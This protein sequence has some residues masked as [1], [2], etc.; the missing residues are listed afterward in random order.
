M[1]SEESA[2]VGFRKDS[3]K[4]PGRLGK[5]TD[6]E[7]VDNEQVSRFGSFHTDWAAQI[8]YFGQVNVPYIVRNVI[9]GDLPA[10]PIDT[11]NSQFVARL[12]VGNHRDIRVPAIV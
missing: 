11:F 1:I 8:V 2:A 7:N 4:T 12:Y 10:R 6:I 9:I 5:D 3:G